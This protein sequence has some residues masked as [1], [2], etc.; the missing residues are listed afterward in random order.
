[1]STFR[2]CGSLTSP[3][4]DSVWALQA[5]DQLLVVAYDSGSFRVWD[6]QRNI[7]HELN[8]PT[9]CFVTVCLK[10]L[11]LLIPSDSRTEIRAYA[12]DD[13]RPVLKRQVPFSVAGLDEWEGQLVTMTDDTL[14]AYDEDFVCRWSSG[15]PAEAIGGMVVARDSIW[16]IVKDGCIAFWRGQR[17]LSTD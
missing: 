6:E 16:A 2:A 5:C 15:V 3:E 8:V 11:V 13:F 17:K 12:V 1:M 7:R 10:R 9:A 14:L 4:A